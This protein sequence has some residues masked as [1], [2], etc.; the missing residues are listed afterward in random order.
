MNFCFDS[1]KDPVTKTVFA[2]ANWPGKFGFLD[3]RDTERERERER[4]AP[5]L[6][7]IL[8]DFRLCKTP[9]IAQRCRE[10]LK[11]E[12]G[13]MEKDSSSC[14]TDTSRQLWELPGICL[15]THT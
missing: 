4:L 8:F 9:W 14:C 6:L 10:A 15:Q 1:E 11:E 5:V 12:S 13:D 7:S 2:C 3:G